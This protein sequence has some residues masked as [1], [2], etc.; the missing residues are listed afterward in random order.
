MSESGKA[1]IVTL[2]EAIH[3]IRKQS[4]EKFIASMIDGKYLELCA[5]YP[6]DCIFCKAERVGTRCFERSRD[7]SK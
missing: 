7:S 2:E 1:E 3:I 5:V 4:S 6:S